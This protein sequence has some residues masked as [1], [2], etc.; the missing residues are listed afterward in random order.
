MQGRAATAAAK[1]KKPAAR[2]G[3]KSSWFDVVG[4]SMD[5]QVVALVEAHRKQPGDYEPKPS[6]LCAALAWGRVGLLQQLIRMGERPVVGE[7]PLSV[8]LQASSNVLTMLDL[9]LRMPDYPWDEP[10]SPE[11]L[12]TQLLP[13][14]PGLPLLKLM[15]N[16]LLRHP[17]FESLF[18]YR[19]HAT[20]ETPL[21]LAAR[22]NQDQTVGWLLAEGIAPLPD[23]NNGA[24]IF[25]PI[26]CL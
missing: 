3:A 2:R 18:E 7:R 13:L 14:S 15:R 23:A 6:V 8:A 9:L 5:S 19:A 4:N 10:T 26:H 12:I 16:T 22:L 17:H 1:K 11:H 24:Y 20:L 21:L 25:L